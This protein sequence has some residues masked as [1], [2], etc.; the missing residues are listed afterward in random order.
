MIAYK[1]GL[2]SNRQSLLFGL[3]FTGQY[4]LWKRLSLHRALVVVIPT[5]IGGTQKLTVRLYQICGNRVCDYSSPL[6]TGAAS[7]ATAVE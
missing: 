5:L 7:G 4:L 1:T 3:S 2:T 6:A